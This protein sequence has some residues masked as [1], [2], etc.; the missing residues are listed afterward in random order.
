MWRSKKFIISAV[1]ALIILAAGIGG[2]A[3]AD[4][5]DEDTSATPFGTLWEKMATVLQEDGIDV[6]SDQLQSAFTEAK[7]GLRAEAMQSFLDEMVAQEKITQEQ[8]D[9]YRDWIEAKPD[10]GEGFGFG[11]R[12]GGPGGGRFEFRMRGPGGFHGFGGF[13][14]FC[15]QVEETN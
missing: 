9:A 5:G 13:G 7:E 11:G 1:L 3:L 14:G 10:M 8:A 6:T 12:F 15:P 4:N 2:V